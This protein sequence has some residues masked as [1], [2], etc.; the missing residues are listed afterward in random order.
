MLRA[1]RN[2]LA[3]LILSWALTEARIVNPVWARRAARKGLGAAALHAAPEDPEVHVLLGMLHSASMSGSRYH[4]ALAEAGLGRVEHARRLAQEL[5][6]DAGGRTLLAAAAAP[7]DPAFA[8][9][10]LPRSCKSARIACRIAFGDV[11]G[12]TTDACEQNGDEDLIVTAALHAARGEYVEARRR[13]NQLFRR[14]GLVEP[15]NVDLDER[16]SLTAFEAAP[17]SLIKNDPRCVSV[18]VPYRNA[19]ATLDMALSSLR[20]QTHGNI[21][22]LVV[23]DRSQ[24]DSIRIAER[25]ATEDPRIRLLSNQRRPGAYGARNTGL[26][27]ALGRFVTFHDADD[28]AHPQRLERQIGAIAGMDASVCRYFRLG[29]DGLIVNPR[30]FP[31]LRTNPILMM[32]RHEALAEVG[33]FDEVAAGGDSE[34]LARTETLR[35][36]WRVARMPDCLVVA[37]WSS[38]SLMGSPTTGIVGEGA[39]KRI[40][41]VEEWRRRHA[42]LAHQGA[43]WRRALSR[44]KGLAYLK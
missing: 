26:L 16:L 1:S 30:I 43:P 21:E 7:F 15:L 34:F 19:D 28:W 6:L 25:H 17:A 22:I 4:W 2:R 33:L 13:L 44:G 42:E 10:L 38:T 32:I 9:E 40:A 23:N 39:A 37:S 3:L 29:N 27:A 24:D 11:E 8:F 20:R 31:L 5:A 36:R 14:H 35:G 12:L 18:I 41:Y